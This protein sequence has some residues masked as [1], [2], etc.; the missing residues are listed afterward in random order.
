MCD[1]IKTNCL[2][3]RTA[4]SDGNDI[5]IL[6]LEG[7]RAMR[8]DILVPFLITTVLPDVM[9]IISSDDNSTLH[10]GRHDLTDQNSATN[11]NITSER[12]FLVNVTT[13]DGGIRGF[14]TKTNILHKTHWLS[15]DIANCTLTCDEDG[16][17]FL[18]RLL[19][20]IALDIFPH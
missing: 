5:A 18:V 19:V 8:W 16:I 17:L 12:T 4:L 20:L 14:D 11:R 7:R 9:K 3:Q 15:T 1:N 13:F 6:N 2:R 10:F